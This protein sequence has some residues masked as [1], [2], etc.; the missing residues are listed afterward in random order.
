MQ[1][2]SFFI[3][4]KTQNVQAPLQYFFKEDRIL[5]PTGTVPQSGYSCVH[6]TVGELH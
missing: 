4:F 3:Y 1:I 2:I 6:S 5:C